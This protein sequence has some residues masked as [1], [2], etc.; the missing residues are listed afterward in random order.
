MAFGDIV[1]LK[2]RTPLGPFSRK[3]IQEGLGRG[4]FDARDL[5][6]TPGLKDWLPLLE[7][8]HHLDREVVDWPRDREGRSLPPLPNAAQ[9]AEKADRPASGPVVETAA[10]P[11]A[12]FPPL[13][14]RFEQKR[15]EM[16]PAEKA[17]P[18][19]LPELSPVD[20]TVALL[21][22]K[23][24]QPPS[25]E[26]AHAPESAPFMTRAFAFAID[27]GVL[28]L[29]IL[30]VFGV[31]YLIWYIRG[32]IE[33]RDV[34]TTRQEQALLWRNLRDLVLIVANGFAWIYAAG[35]ESSRWQGTI[36]KQALS[37]IVT[38]E[39]GERVS[40]LRATG[41]H[42]AKYLSALPLFL[43]FMAAL[44]RPQRLTW[45]DRLAATRV[46]KRNPNPR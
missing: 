40:F 28:F 16:P 36:G 20:P 44:V 31:A 35:L 24:T 9:R 2:N 12:S 25:L 27:L 11:T 23:R 5:A 17:K 34:E 37:L 7:V 19:R 38:D 33:H 22:E 26:L 6:H 18:P 30:V 15:E 4:E 3:Q 8:L 1:L 46:T 14:N 13:P 42:A 32:P 39:R 43:G 21:S 29:P 41:R 10:P 45:H